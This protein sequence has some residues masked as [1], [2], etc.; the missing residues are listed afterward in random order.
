MQNLNSS[1]FQELVPPTGKII[2]EETG[3]TSSGFSKSPGRRRNGKNLLLPLVRFWASAAMNLLHS[4]TIQYQP[5]RHLT[6]KA[7]IT[8][9]WGGGLPSIIHWTPS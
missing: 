5:Q 1:R 3:A 9:M 4:I 8:G 6:T 7:I 2:A